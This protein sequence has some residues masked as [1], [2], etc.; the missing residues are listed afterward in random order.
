MLKLTLNKSLSV[1]LL[2]IAGTGSIATSASAV[3]AGN[4]V[5]FSYE[6]KGY[7]LKD[8][9]PFLQQAYYDA[10]VEA[11]DSLNRVLEQ[12]V[13]AMYIENKANESGRSIQEMRASLFNYEPATQ[14][15]VKALY[16]QYKDQ[17]DMPFGQVEPQLREELEN[18]KRQEVIQTLIARV[19]KESGFESKLPQPEAPSL[20]MDLSPYPWKGA[21]DASITVVEFA[22]YNCGYCRTAK[23]D[24]DKLMKQYKDKI[25]LYYVDYLVTERGVPGSST[26]TARGAYCAGKQ[27]KF[28]EFFNLAYEKP[29]TMTTSGDLAKTLK[30]DQKAFAACVTSDDSAQFVLDSHQL[31]QD[32]GVTG[33]PTFF[34]NGQRLHT[35]DPAI[36]LKAE[37][38]K[39][40]KQK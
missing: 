30:L 3:A 18:R 20:A 38:E 9:Q 25:K 11:R 6:G 24:I 32:L 5:L 21:S 27:D 29:V 4:D 19:K 34:V 16:E 10:E 15:E 37:I 33:T 7:Q 22:D 17:I 28:R 2:S 31:A 12:A 36:D 35:H 23:P 8:M 26:A 40:L 1:L 39:R 13:V 14:K